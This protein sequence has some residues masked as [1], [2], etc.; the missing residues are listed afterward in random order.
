MVSKFVRAA[1][2]VA[3]QGMSLFDLRG[4]VCGCLIGVEVLLE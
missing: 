4:L 3:Q 1:M 2:Q